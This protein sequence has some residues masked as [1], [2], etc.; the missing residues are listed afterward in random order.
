MYLSFPLTGERGE[1]QT[2][3]IVNFANSDFFG[4]PRGEGPAL[5]SLDVGVSGQPTR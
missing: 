4:A 3:F 2:L 1:R 5:L